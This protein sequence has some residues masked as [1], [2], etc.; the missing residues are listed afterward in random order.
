LH[1]IKRNIEEKTEVYE[2]KIQLKNFFK[3]ITPHIYNLPTENLK[4][5]FMEEFIDR[6]IEIYGTS[7]FPYKYIKLFAH[8]PLD[9]Q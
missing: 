5:E 1:I 9:I 8:C 3:A 6:Y 7:V 4:E 2:N